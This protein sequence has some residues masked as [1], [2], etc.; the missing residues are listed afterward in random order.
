MITRHGD[1]EIDDSRSRF[2]LPRVHRW[3]TSTYWSAGVTLEKVTRAHENSALIVGAY[4]ADQQVGCLRVVSDK[5]TFAWLGDV[6]VDES[7]RRKGLAL[8]MTKFALA[9]PEFQGL[10]KWMLATRDA[11][12]IYAAAGFKVVDKP[13]TLMW[14]SSST[15]D[16][17]R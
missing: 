1:Y 12:P 16:P 7:H 5:T 11:H 4:L 13:Q 6:F 2:D 8:A 9:H 15:W 3:L 10:R 14:L 17:D